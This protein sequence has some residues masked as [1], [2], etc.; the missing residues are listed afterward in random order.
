LKTQNKG[1]WS[2]WIFAETASRGAAFTIYNNLVKFKLFNVYA[3]QN[4]KQLFFLNFNWC[5]WLLIVCGL[6]FKVSKIHNLKVNFFFSSQKAKTV[7]ILITFCLFYL[8]SVLS[9]QT[10]TIPRYALP[11]YPFLYLA[12]SVLFME[13]FHSK[14][15]LFKVALTVLPIV[16]Y[17]QLF[18]SIDPVSKKLWGEIQVLD[19]TLYG[20]NSHL[21]GNDGM[22]YNI[23]YLKILKGRTILLEQ[24]PKQPV[25]CQW[26]IP[27]PNNE[28]KTFKILQIE[29][30]KNILCGK[31]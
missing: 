25:N 17:L 4:W 16:T 8:I 12:S 11:I 15:L 23:Q 6:I 24:K 3:Y 21:S 5:F 7:A 20:L 29:I 28:N 26:I 13:M 10:Y 30:N 2:D 14:K 1:L 22:T 27:D 18:Y 19:E 31:Y 9:F